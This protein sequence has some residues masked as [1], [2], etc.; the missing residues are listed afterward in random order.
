MRRCPKIV[1]RFLA[2]SGNNA[3]DFVLVLPHNTYRSYLVKL[4]VTTP[5]YIFLRIVYMYVFYS[6]VPCIL[7]RATAILTVRSTA[8]S[9]SRTR[10]LCRASSPAAASASD[11]S[12]D[13]DVTRVRPDTGTCAPT[14]LRDVNVRTHCTARGLLVQFCKI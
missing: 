10:T 7:Q 1:S 12:A 4:Q 8:A 2:S 11:S 9:V 5:L 3:A 6:M 14:T 13:V